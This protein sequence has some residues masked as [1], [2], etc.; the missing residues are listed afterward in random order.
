MTILT[1]ERYGST[2]FLNF[3]KSLLLF[4][5]EFL[6]ILPEPWLVKCKTQNMSIFSIAEFIST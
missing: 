3:N 6:H 2:R 1:L 5:L 4:I